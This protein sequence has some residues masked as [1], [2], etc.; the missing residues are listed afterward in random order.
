MRL[1]FLLFVGALCLAF[2]YATGLNDNTIQDDKVIALL[3]LADQGESHANEG[4]R[5]VRAFFG[6]GGYCCRGYGYGYG[7]R[8]GGYGRGGYGRGYYGRRRYGYWG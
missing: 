2:S 1:T 8:R 4:T 7:Y 5:E 6:G 3:N